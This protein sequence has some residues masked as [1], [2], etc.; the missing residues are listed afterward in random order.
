MQSKAD[1]ADLYMID[2]LS[3]SRGNTTLYFRASSTFLI[4]I[5]Q[6]WC[7]PFMYTM[8]CLVVVCSCY[9]GLAINSIQYIMNLLSTNY[10]YFWSLFFCVLVPDYLNA[11]TILQ[12]TCPAHQN[13]V[14]AHTDLQGAPILEYPL[15]YEN[16]LITI[17][18]FMLL[19]YCT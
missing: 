5:S 11:R 1:R 16:N 3:I 7:T 13:P 6:L 2:R 9:H 18:V 17:Y 10:P 4:Y 15:H 12:H 8:I 19:R 14:I